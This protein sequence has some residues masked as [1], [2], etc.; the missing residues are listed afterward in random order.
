MTAYDGPLDIS[1]QVGHFSI[2]IAQMEQDG[3]NITPWA[4]LILAEVVS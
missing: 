4:F 2:E 3:E 1:I